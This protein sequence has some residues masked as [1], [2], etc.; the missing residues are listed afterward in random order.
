M[1]KTQT[2]QKDQKVQWHQTTASKAGAGTVLQEIAE[3][4]HLFV[5]ENLSRNGS[6]KR[7]ELFVDLEAAASSTSTSS[8]VS[9][10][11]AKQTNP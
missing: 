10:N 7:H 1:A 4:K 11:G 8:S 6:V 3:S 5:I 2:K 9:P